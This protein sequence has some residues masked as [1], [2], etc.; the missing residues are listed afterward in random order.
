MQHEQNQKKVQM[1]IRTEDWL[2]YQLEVHL[3]LDWNV[4]DNV[5]ERRLH[6]VREIQQVLIAGFRQR[7]DAAS[8]QQTV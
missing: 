1:T 7:Q 6:R 5:I 8:Q 3:V 2:T 4:T